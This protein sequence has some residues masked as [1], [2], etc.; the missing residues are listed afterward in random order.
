MK[1]SKQDSLKEYQ[2]RYKNYES[3]KYKARYN[4]SFEIKDIL[5]ITD[6]SK[7]ELILIR[8]LMLNLLNT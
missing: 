8:D 5:A 7:Q 4:L 6:F 2:K 1:I 3:D